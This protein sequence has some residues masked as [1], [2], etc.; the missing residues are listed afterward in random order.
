M[1]RI[2]KR[3]HLAA[4]LAFSFAASA[5]APAPSDD[6]EKS[7]SVSL[8]AGK[9]VYQPGEAVDLVLTVTNRSEEALTLRFSSAKQYDF[10]IKKDGRELWQWSKGKMFAMALTSLRLGPAESR[11]FHGSWP[12]T[13]PSGRQ[14]EPGSYR[15]TAVLPL[16]GRPLSAA[17]TIEILK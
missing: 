5:G 2:F 3:A 8:T 11:R 15:A 4:C 1:S 14:V 9:P 6:V 12:Q 10:V 17:T 16:L 7:V 13:D